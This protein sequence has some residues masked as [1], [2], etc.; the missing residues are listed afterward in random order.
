[1]NQKIANRDEIAQFLD[2]LLNIEHIRDYCPNGLQV[3]GK[4]DIR[5]IISG[6]TA[7]LALIHAAIEAQADAVLVHHGFFWRDEDPRII[8]TKY[9]RV[10]KLMVHD[11]NLFAYHIPLDIHPVLGNNA[12]LA[13]LLNL[14]AS[15]PLREDYPG[16]IGA[17]NNA[18]VK[19]IGD[20]AQLIELRLK[21]KPLLIG[22]PT[23]PVKKIGWCTGAAQDMITAAARQGANVYISGEISE[24][25]VHEARENNIAYLACGHHATERYG[26]QALGDAL[27]SRFGIKHRFIEIDNPV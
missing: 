21:R 11:I 17:V 7:S 10:K 14:Q 2:Q 16:C 24:R 23:Q 9:M 15:M 4:N 6:V 27:A 3:E 20:L 22:D 1:M 8:G 13:K 19:T 5:L 26:I 25:T 18:A 12:Q